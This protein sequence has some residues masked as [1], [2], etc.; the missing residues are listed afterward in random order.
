MMIPAWY[1]Y[2]D[3]SKE[4]NDYFLDSKSHNQKSNL[5]ETLVNNIMGDTSISKIPVM[6]FKDALGIH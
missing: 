5:R 2:K 1:N 4:Y 3:L 6:I